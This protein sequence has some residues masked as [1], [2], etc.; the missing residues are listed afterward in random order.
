M[1]LSIPLIEDIKFDKKELYKSF[2]DI[3]SII[4]IGILK[5]FKAVFNDSLI[6]NYGF[7]ILLFIFLLFILK[8]I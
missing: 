3:K 2:I 7:F 6:Y 5:C 4:N 1:K 8:I